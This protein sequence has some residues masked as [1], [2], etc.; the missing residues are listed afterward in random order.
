MVFAHVKK[1]GIFLSRRLRRVKDLSVSYAR[2]PRHVD[3]TAVSR[4]ERAHV[5][6]ESTD[7]F[8]F[9]SQE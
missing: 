1:S 2:G 9:V 3:E 7:S 8:P 6:R 5:S 4:H